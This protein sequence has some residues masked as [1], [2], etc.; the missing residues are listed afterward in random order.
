MI[1]NPDSKSNELAIDCSGNEKDESWLEYSDLDKQMFSFRLSA[2]SLLSS[3]CTHPL[4]VI[5]TRQQAGTSVTGDTIT[6]RHIISEILHNAKVYGIPS[7]FRGWIP[8]TV[9]GLPSNVIYMNIIESSRE[10]IQHQLKKNTS[11][12]PYAID[13]IQSSL[14]SVLANGISL[15]PYV[16]AEVISNRLITQGRDNIGIRRMILQIYGESGIRGFLNGFGVSFVYC[17]LFRFA[18]STYF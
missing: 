2:F 13:G 6:G 9:L 10:A 1:L 15:I 4:N 12:S 14:S 11:L 7:L 8:L 5:T 16:P 17:S 3:I 18:K